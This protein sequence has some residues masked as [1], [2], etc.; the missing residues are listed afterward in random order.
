VSDVASTYEAGGNIDRD[1]QTLY[2]LSVGSEPS[3]ALQGKGR[4]G[5][6][7]KLCSPSDRIQASGT[8]C[9]KIQS[10]NSQA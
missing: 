10:C 9:S 6:N 7:S 1:K 4:D 3:T 8:L 2:A 5:S